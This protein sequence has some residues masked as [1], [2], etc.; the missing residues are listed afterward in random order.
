MIVAIDGPAASGKSTTAKLLAKK[1]D[2]IHLNSGL[3]YRAVT[4]ILIEN[5]LLNNITD[6][7]QLIFKNLQFK[8]QNLDIVYYTDIEITDK[9]YDEEI[10]KNINIVSNNY[11]VRK[12]LIEHQRFLVKNKNV[13]CEGRDIGSVVFPNAEFKFYLNADIDTR[14]ERRFEDLRKNNSKVSKKEIIENIMN[15]DKNDKSRKI[16][17][18]IKVKD[19]IEVNTTKLTINQQVE[20][21]YSII[22]KNRK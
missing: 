8:G 12:K 3:M 2:F 19:C 10:N 4:F 14:A 22:I 5:S 21:I 16:S 1:M 18:L 13:I 7:I 11:F 6:S 15:R 20:Y 9:L 17:P